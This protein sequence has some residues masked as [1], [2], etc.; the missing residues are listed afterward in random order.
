MTLYAVGDL[1]G[2]LEP[3]KQLMSYV[4]FDPSKDQLWLT[5]DLVNRGPDSIGCLQFVKNLGDS[6]KTVLGNHDL[7]ILAIHELKLKTNDTDIQK[8]LAYEQAPQLLA[9]LAKQ[10]ILVRDK[11]RKLIMTHAGV[12]PV[13]TDKQARKL[14]QD[15]E[16]VLSK[17]KQRKLFFA[18]MYGN[19]PDTW[20]DTLAGNERLRYIVN[21]FTRMR[22]CA[23]DSTLDFKF[24]SSPNNPPKGMKSWFVWP[25]KRKHRL[26]FGHWAALMGHTHRSDIIGL[27]TGYVWAN[28]LTL[29]D[30][31]NN[32]RYCCDTDGNITE[33]SE[34]EFECLKKPD[35]W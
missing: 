13:W 18:S 20:K 23:E 14:A 16:Q 30:M 32:I 12:P 27:D 4:K 28:H 34:L 35:G 19:T 6:A 2:C 10:P 25:K 31:D 22:F 11:D 24:K 33:Y 15:L 26:V 7:H 5:G 8:T 21:A 9:W 17:K 3:L 29:M 1:Q